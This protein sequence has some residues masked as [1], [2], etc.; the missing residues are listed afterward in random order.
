[1]SLKENLN[2]MGRK[3]KDINKKQMKKL[4]M[5]NKVTNMKIYIKWELQQIGIPK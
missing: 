1:M 4:Y 3:S 5:K 2:T